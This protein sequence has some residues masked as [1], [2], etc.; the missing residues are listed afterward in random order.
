MTGVATGTVAW[1]YDT[2]FRANHEEVN[3]AFGVD[4]YFD[5][6][7]LPASIGEL[8]LTREASTG[9]VSVSSVSSVAT[10][11][12]YTPFGE[13]ASATT[14]EGE[15]ALL[16]LAFTYDVLGRIVT[17]TDTGV[18]WSYGYDLAGRLATVKKDGVNVASYTYDLNGNRLN[19]GATYDEEDRQLSGS[20]AT[21]TYTPNGERKTRANAT[22]T[23]TNGYDGRGHFINVALPQDKTYAVGLAPRGR[24][25]SR[26]ESPR[27]CP[28]VSRAIYPR[29]KHAP[30]R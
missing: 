17:K 15:N 8:S 27:A 4:V 12:A 14:K 9:R 30:R 25:V 16:D 5:D 19:D 28:S 10:P 3:G 1:T 11:F 20:G 21:F 18:A 2:R 13:L 26:S 23:T 22:G 7:S 6:D 24:R 29:W